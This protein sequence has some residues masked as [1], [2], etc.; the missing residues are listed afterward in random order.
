MEPL[1][2]GVSVQ[3][4]APGTLYPRLGARYELA[5][6]RERGLYGFQL[7]QPLMRSGRYALGVS[8][9]RVTDHLDLQQVDDLENSLALLLARNDYR[10]Y[11]E[12]EGVGAYLIWRVPDFSDVSVHL[13]SDDYRSI[14]LYAS[15][16]SWFRRDRPLRDNPAIDAGRARTATLRLE[17]LAHLAHRTRAGFYHWIEIERAGRG[18]GGDFDY[19]RA[20]ADLRAVVRVSPA[21]TLT[22]RGVAGTTP[23]GALPSQKEFALG[24]ADGLRAHA[25]GEFRGNQAALVQAEYGAGLWRLHSRAFE[26]GLH[27]LAFLDAGR[28]WT[29]PDRAWDARRQPFAVDAG[30]G[31][32]SSEDNLRIYLARNLQQPGSGMVVSVR[33]QRPF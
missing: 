24:G 9:V 26:G 27:A 33:L 22:L 15:T 30:L 28:A 11:F 4:Q 1:R 20:L 18:L 25:L 13:R 23:A 17:R 7:E 21:G 6:G 32:G 5:T 16:R 12:R 19:T 8:A 2:I 29:N 14:P 10:D 31:L 3:A